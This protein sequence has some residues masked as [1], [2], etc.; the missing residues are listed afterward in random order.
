[1]DNNIKKPTEFDNFKKLVFRY[2]CVLENY[3]SDSSYINFTRLSN[4]EK[5]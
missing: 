5:K 1:M 4:L 2:R 3:K